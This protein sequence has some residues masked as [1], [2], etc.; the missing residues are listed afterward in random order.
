MNLLFGKKIILNTTIEFLSKYNSILLFPGVAVEKRWRNL[1][2]SFK[3]SI[4]EG[5]QCTGRK[6][7][8]RQ[9]L[10]YDQLFFL[11]KLI[12]PQVLTPEP[13]INQFKV[14]KVKEE[15]PRNKIYIKP[16]DLETFSNTDGLDDHQQ[17]FNSL[18]P[19][20]RK[21]DDDQVLNFRAE[22]IALIQNIRR[23]IK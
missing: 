18:L 10:Y 23:G 6:R 19:I 1:R 14:E 11:Y 2:D 3:K 20:V 17:F 21:L 7:R 5:E 16:N 13:I 22:V 8:K 4:K 9:Y 12:D 15:K